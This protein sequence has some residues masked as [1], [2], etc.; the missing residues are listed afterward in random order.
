[1]DTQASSFVA[2]VFSGRA[3]AEAAGQELHRLGLDDQAIEIGLPDPGRYLIERN[4]SVAV[5]QGVVRGVLIGIVA[6]GVI[7]MGFVL[8]TVPSPTSMTLNAQAL[9]FLI[10]GFWGIFFGGLGGMVPAVLAHEQAARWY[11]VTPDT[12]EIVVVA[13]T[14]TLPR[15]ARTAMMRNGAR[16]LLDQA[17][18]VHPL[19]PSGAVQLPA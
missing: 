7:G 3:Q 19:A 8:A 4:E 1:M 14:E 13:H 10:G 16:Y 2:G 6:G 17:P 9:G 11:A 18:S 12:S 15:S 5:G